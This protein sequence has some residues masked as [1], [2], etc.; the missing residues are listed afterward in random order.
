MV[1]GQYQ[2]VTN[3]H[4]AAD[5]VRSMASVASDLDAS[6]LNLCSVLAPH[7]LQQAGLSVPLAD[8]LPASGVYVVV[9]NAG[10]GFW[11][12]VRAGH[13]QL[14]TLL[15]ALFDENGRGKIGDPVDQLSQ[16][17]VETAIENHLPA[18]RYELLFPPQSAAPPGFLPLQ[19]L[20]RVAGWHQPSPLGS[21]MHPVF[22]LWFAYR[23]VVW[24]DAESVTAESVAGPTEST[25]EETAAAQSSDP[26]SDHCLRCES[27]ACVTACPA[28]AI[29]LADSPDMSAC[30]G[31]RLAQDSRCADRC[32]AREA[33]PAVESRAQY[34][35][36]QIRYHYRLALHTL[37]R[38]YG[39]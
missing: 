11:N 30:A 36:E 25:T 34:P 6:G 12:S 10:S 38:Y 1:K 5:F 28:S 7:Q 3:Q 26:L 33:C 17:L 31:F 18:A 24:I 8:H 37:R 9:G 23:A 35:R 15:E 16:T 20:G 4:Y 32:L 2:F 21:G 13:P 22:G 27:Q 29:T 39:E 19:Q 14:Q